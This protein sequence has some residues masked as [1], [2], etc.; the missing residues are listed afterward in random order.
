MKA[1]LALIVIY[2]GMFFVAIQGGSPGSVQAAAQSS[3]NNQT[4]TKG[5]FA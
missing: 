4:Q 2:V 3:I 1:A 5:H